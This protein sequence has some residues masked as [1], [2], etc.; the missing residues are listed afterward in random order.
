VSERDLR[1]GT[2]ETIAIQQKQKVAPLRE[3]E[4]VAKLGARATIGG[5]AISGTPQG[6]G[7]VPA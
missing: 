2:S 1:G 4:L 7:W 6:G 5:S 3:H